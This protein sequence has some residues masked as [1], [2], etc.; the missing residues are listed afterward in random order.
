MTPKTNDKRK[1]ID[2]TVLHQK[3]Y[4][5]R[6]SVKK[7]KSTLHVIYLVGLSLEH[8]K[9]SHNPAIKTNDSI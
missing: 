8:M 1:I 7:V 6:D 4:D 3:F 9:N 2:R 5:S